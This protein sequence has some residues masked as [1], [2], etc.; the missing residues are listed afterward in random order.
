MQVQ[1]TSKLTN[2]ETSH[3]CYHGKQLLLLV[4]I[5]AGWYSGHS[6]RSV[7]SS[8]ALE[9]KWK[10]GLEALWQLSICVAVEGEL[11]RV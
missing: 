7:P 2:E 11:V 4:G 9:V 1:I 8:L 3:K 6:D 5:P 10:S